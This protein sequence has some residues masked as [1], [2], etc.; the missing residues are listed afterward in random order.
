M[1]KI[2][3]L[4]TALF[5]LSISTLCIVAITVDSQNN[6]VTIT[7]DILFGDKSVAEGIT[8]LSKAH[9]GQHLFWNT[10]YTIGENAE[11]ETEYKFYSSEQ[12]DTDLGA[13]YF[14]QIDTDIRYGLDMQT[15]AEEQ[16]GLARVYKELYDS[17][18]I[19]EKVEK[20]VALKDIY[21]YYPLRLN[22]IL[23]NVRWSNNDYESLYDDEPGSE[24]YVVNKF[25]EF[26]RIPILDGHEVDISISRNKNGVS[27]S[28]GSTSSSEAY[29][30]Y[31]SSV[32]AYTE[33]T[34]FF[35]IRN[36]TYKGNYADFS[37]VPGGYGIYSFKYRHG[38][39]LAYTGIDADSLANVYPLDADLT[40]E[41]IS[42]SEDGKY[43]IMVGIKNDKDTVFTVIDIETMTK[44][45][46]III[47]DKIV[48]NVK[49]VAKKLAIIASGNY[50]PNENESVKITDDFIVLIFSEEFALIEI[51]EDGDYELKFIAK[52]PNYIDEKFQYMDYYSEMVYDG[53]KLIIVNSLYPDGSPELCGY[54]MAIY[55][56]SGLIY[57]TKYN[58]SLDVNNKNRI[59]DYNCHPKND[60]Y[61]IILNKE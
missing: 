40:V 32:S 60:A 5:I 21:E 44:H 6:T 61:T 1:K 7:E 52:Q 48:Y 29:D 47:E 15:P 26:F 2:L 16:V 41:H 59:Y 31:F 50:I 12:Y 58:S 51:S 27:I 37:L 56:Q 14:F 28:S 22:I 11:P 4:V 30:Y 38:P 42:I 3:I 57:Y 17:C 45:D 33:D 8:V 53:E 25:R 39:L 24:K 23:P 35:T 18:E 34:V 13:S 55:D 46:E 19:G 36:K 54:Y 9:Y 43:L 20:T 10:E 49:E